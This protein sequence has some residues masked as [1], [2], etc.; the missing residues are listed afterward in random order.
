VSRALVF[1]L[2]LPACAAPTAQERAEVYDA[3]VKLAQ[4]T[5]VAMLVDKEVPHTAALEDWCILV[6]QGRDGCQP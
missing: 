6:L 5:C 1:C 3:N 4:S 2:L